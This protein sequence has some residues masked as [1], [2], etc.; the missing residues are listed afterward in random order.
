MFL[1]IYIYIIKTPSAKIRGTRFDV[2]VTGKN[3]WRLEKRRFDDN[4]LES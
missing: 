4:K 3:A 1:F 2:P